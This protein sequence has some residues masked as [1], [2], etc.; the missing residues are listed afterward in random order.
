MAWIS[1]LRALFRRNKFTRELD[2]AT[3]EKQLVDKL[4]ELYRQ[5][6]IE[7]PDHILKEGVDALAQSRFVY[8]PPKPGLGN[9]EERRSIP[10]VPASVP[11]SWTREVARPARCTAFRWR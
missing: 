7:V 1:R 6:G 2:E 4:R 9:P 5:Q 3:R 8:D 10:T 11:T